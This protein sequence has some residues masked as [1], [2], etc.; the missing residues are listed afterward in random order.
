MDGSFFGSIIFEGIGAFFRWIC[1]FILSKIRGQKPVSLKQVWEGNKDS[2]FQSSVEYGFS[3]IILGV[4]IVLVVVII[5][6]E[7]W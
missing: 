7:W 6:R 1:L 3:N 5:L 2:S 4:I